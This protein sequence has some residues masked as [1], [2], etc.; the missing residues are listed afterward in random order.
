MTQEYIVHR[1]AK[2]LGIEAIREAQTDMLRKHLLYAK[3]H[4]PAYRKILA[5]IDVEHFELGGLPQLPFTEKK[6]I[7][8]SPNSFLAVAPDQI[9]DMVLSSGTT[10]KPL[11]INYTDRDLAR[12]SYNEEESF[13]SCGIERGD[14]ALLTCTLDRCF[15][16]GLAYYLGLRARGAAVIRNGHGVI[17]SHVEIICNMQPT[18]IVGVPTFLRKL[19]LFM[20]K[21]NQ[22]A[23]KISVR[24]II[25]I[26]EPLR[27]RN[28]ESLGLGKE[29]EEIWNAK[30]FSTYASSETITSF[31]ECSAQRGGH[32]IPELAVVEIIDDEG[33]VLSAGETGEIVVTPM[34]VEGMPLVRYKTGDISFLEEVACACGRFSS[35]LGPILGRKNQLMKV[36]GTSLYPQ[37]IFAVLESIHAIS[38]YYVEVS[39]ESELSDRLIVFISLQNKNVTKEKLEEE[40][41]AKLRVKPEIILVTDEILKKKIFLPQFRKPVRFCDKRKVYVN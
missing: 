15:V 22:G 11:Q 27:G 35:R 33:R 4:S 8:N 13:L 1:D 20:R 14:I 18:V 10:G 7:E 24:K 2:F 19:G 32:L 21:S 34:A 36:R 31:C 39:N 12:L 40:L 25:C 37:A 17:E 30:V 16:A 9:A 29:L 28:F 6:D 5:K 23:L 41:A 3:T 26:G 38:N